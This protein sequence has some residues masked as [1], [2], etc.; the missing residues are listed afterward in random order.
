MLIARELTIYDKE[1]VLEMVE[2]IRDFD[3]NFEGLGLLRYFK[4]YEELL[5]ILRYNKIIGTNTLPHIHQTTFGIFEN[6]KL[7]GGFNLRHELK[8]NLINHGGHIGYL[9]RPS[10]RNKGYGTRLLKLAVEEAKKININSVLI[11]CDIH[12]KISEKVI[13]NNN[14]KYENNYYDPF[15]L[16]T[17]KRYWIKIK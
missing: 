13:L 3:Q 7:L 11:T 8:G 10:E 2:E 1:Q 12:N 16:Q 15:D 9:I 5:E 17:Y 6:G 14:G 4:S